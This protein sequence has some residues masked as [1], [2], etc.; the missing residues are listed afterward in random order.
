MTT[1]A[2]QRKPKPNWREVRLHRVALALAIILSA[3]WLAPFPVHFIAWYTYPYEFVLE[4]SRDPLV[5][6]T[7]TPLPDTQVA[8]LTG[9]RVQKFGFSFQVPWENVEPQ[10]HDSDYVEFLD[11]EG[12]THLMLENPD[13]SLKSLADLAKVE[14]TQRTS[15][16]ALLGAD[17][18]RSSFDLDSAALNAKPSDV[19]WWNSRSMQ[20]RSFMLLNEKWMLLM[21]FQSVHAVASSSIRGFQFDGKNG[22]HCKLLLFDAKDRQYEIELLGDGSLTQ[23]QINAI[24]ASFQPRP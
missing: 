7:P 9:L 16:A 22:K 17:A 6:I 4:I 1:Q 12:G 5:W 24:V 15:F 19:H 20:A 21:G 3:V 18:I 13:R 2:E 10:T 23:P 14:P 8:T 11:F